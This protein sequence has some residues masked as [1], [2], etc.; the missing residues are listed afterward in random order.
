MKKFIMPHRVRWDETDAAGVVYFVNYLTYI[1][2][3]EAEVFR[4]LGKSE[5][6]WMEEKDLGFPRVEVFCQYK[7]PIH[8]DEMIEVHSWV[9]VMGRVLLFQGEIYRQGDKK[10][11]AK[12]HLKIMCVKRGAGGDGKSVEVPP[13][14][15]DYL[16]PFIMKGKTTLG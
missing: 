4:S 6:E 5:L 12:G 16:K 8:Y 1:E 14:L 7:S 2:M 3:A 13:D 10:L 11:L 15:L 9:E